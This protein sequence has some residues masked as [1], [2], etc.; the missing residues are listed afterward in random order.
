ML[1][2]VSHELR[3]PLNC[4]IG[5][6]ELLLLESNNEINEYLKKQYIKPALNSNKLL[7]NIIN[8]ILDFSNFEMD[9]FHFKYEYFNMKELIEECLELVH[10]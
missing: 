3:T 1:A 9:G 5:S 10:H 7:L 2:S 6:L 8:D 4:S